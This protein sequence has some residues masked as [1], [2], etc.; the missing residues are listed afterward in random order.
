MATFNT[1]QAAFGQSS[2]NPANLAGGL[3]NA[4]GSMMASRGPSK[5][6]A[7]IYKD[8]M[9]H[10]HGLNKDM[11]T[12]LGGIQTGINRGEQRHEIKKMVL[13]HNQSQEAAATAHVQGLETA[14]TQA[15]LQR[16]LVGQQQRHEVRM[17]SGAHGNAVNFASHI[18]ALA[19]GGTAVNFSHGDINANFTLKK[20]AAAAPT[21][22]AKPTGPKLIGMPTNIAGPK[23][24]AGPKPTV[25]RG[26]GGRMV[27]LNNAKATAPAKKKAAPKQ[28]QPS[29]TRDP[30]TGKI[31]SLKKK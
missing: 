10:E 31:A 15:G 16:R 30:K 29:V 27:S 24:T 25:T 17:Q 20:P 13:G 4:V 26:A 22:P 3:G 19:E 2:A 11:A 6:S 18:G 23:A 7:E 28:A 21:G 9:S 14:T 5:K 1:A 8:M 12:H